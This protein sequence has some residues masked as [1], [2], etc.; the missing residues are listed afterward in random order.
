MAAKGP[1][2]RLDKQLPVVDGWLRKRK[3]WNAREM[4][5][6]LRASV[7]ELPPDLQ[8]EYDLEVRRREEILRSR[9]VEDGDPRIGTSPSLGCR[10]PS[11]LILEQCG[12]LHCHISR[13]G[14]PFISIIL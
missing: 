11:H 9:I 12:E 8:Q 13:R 1:K 6:H 7:A 5:S 2:E 3:L 10:S 14:F 4:L